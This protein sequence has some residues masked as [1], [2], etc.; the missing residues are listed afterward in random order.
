MPAKITK[1]TPKKKDSTQ[2][3]TSQTQVNKSEES[4]NQQ[5]TN[6]PLS[7]KAE[8]S[9]DVP[10]VDINA[11][12]SIE[13]VRGGGP[14]VPE[15]DYNAPI[16]YEQNPSSNVQQIPRKNII[17]FIAGLVFF[18][19]L[20]VA[21][22]GFIL[23]VS[24]DKPQKEVAIEKPK[25]TVS[26]PVKTQKINRGEWQFEVLNGAGVK[27]AAALIA[28]K[29][30]KLGYTIY[31]T[32]NAEA[33]NYTKSQ[34]FVSDSF[35]SKQDLLLEDMQK[36]FG[37]KIISGVVSDASFSARLIVGQDVLTNKDE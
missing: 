18:I 9:A 14:S 36:E 23:F 24:H 28:S 8:N 7:A 35:A 6:A 21:S 33:Q 25:D 26:Q 19:V 4:V 30:E 20:I 1:K 29:L 34:I 10:Q 37:I 15:S 17:M 31:R 27:G 32:G 12:L 2:I 11:P 16:Q 5:F 3:K 22:I 13:T